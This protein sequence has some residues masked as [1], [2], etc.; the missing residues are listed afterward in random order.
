MIEG[1]LSSYFDT[2]H[3]RLLLKALRRRIK[4]PRFMTL[5]CKTIK[6]GH[7]DTV[8]FRAASEGVTQGGALSSLL[9]NVMLN[10]LDHTCMNTN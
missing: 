4:D 10:E 9:S 3:H 8:L 1:D 5:L 2:V 7:V 6:A